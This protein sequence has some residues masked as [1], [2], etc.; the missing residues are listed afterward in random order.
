[1]PQYARYTR[2]HK[3]RLIIVLM[4]PA[5]GM[6]QNPRLFSAFLADYFTQHPADGLTIGLY[7]LKMSVLFVMC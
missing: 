5:P 4:C 1:M 6:R 2:F 7:F 3:F